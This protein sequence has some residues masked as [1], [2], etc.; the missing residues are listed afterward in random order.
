MLPEGNP[1]QESI[2]NCTPMW[3][4]R[5]AQSTA[6]FDK[7]SSS[8]KFWILDW[9]WFYFLELIIVLN[10]LTRKLSELC[11]I[12]SSDVKECVA[13]RTPALLGWKYLVEFLKL[14]YH[15][16][17]LD[18]KT[19]LSRLLDS[20]KQGSQEQTSFMLPIITVFMIEFARSRTLMNRLIMTC[21]SKVEHVQPHRLLSSLVEN[22]FQCLISILQV[23]FVFNC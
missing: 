22:H 4:K 5:N 21:L 6:E 9:D 18:Q 10:F 1:T 11:Q 16:G 2:G 7:W 3:R 14:Q 13:Q 19:T 15:E 12:S 8:E 23:D 17:L 20:F